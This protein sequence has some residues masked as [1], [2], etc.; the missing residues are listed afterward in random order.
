MG[1]LRVP[2]DFLVLGKTQLIL[3]TLYLQVLITQISTQTDNHANR[4]V[5]QKSILKK[6]VCSFETLN[7]TLYAKKAFIFFIKCQPFAIQRSIGP[8]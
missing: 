4:K 2:Q 1:I 7:S 8:F 6:S 5:L 3:A